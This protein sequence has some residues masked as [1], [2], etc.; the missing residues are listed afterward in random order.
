M[1]LKWNLIT[2]GM[3]PH[4]QIRRKLAEKVGKLET[5]LAHFPAD[6]VHLQVVLE[7]N[8]RK[9]Q[10]EAALTLYL[11]AK[12]LRA[13][14]AAADPVPAFDQAIRVLLREISMLKSSLRHESEWSRTIR[15]APAEALSSSRVRAWA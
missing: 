12:V 14:K 11:P 4:Y 3:R 2:K 10:F 9:D 5:H 15:V 6:A 1:T 8:V 7:K 13:A